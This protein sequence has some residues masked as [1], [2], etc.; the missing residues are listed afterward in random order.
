MSKLKGGSGETLPSIIPS[1]LYTLLASV[2]V[3]A[4]LIYTVNVS[5]LEIKND[6][7]KQ[8]LSNLA[9]YVAAKAYGLVSAVT[10]GNLSASLRLN[11]PSVVCDQMYWMQL[12]NDTSLAWVQIG[13]GTT[14]SSTEQQEPIR[15]RVSAAG[16]YA[17][18]SGIATLECW[19]NSTGTYLQLSGGSK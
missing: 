4:L 13:Y 5:T 14:P 8:Q 9:E 2:A 11:I 6:A 18:D 16:V 1:Y 12:G 15:A 3:G 17:S 19:T 7:G 10:A